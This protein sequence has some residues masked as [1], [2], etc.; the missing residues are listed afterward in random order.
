MTGF[1]ICEYDKKWW[2]VFVLHISESDIQVTAFH[3]S[4]ASKSFIYPSPPIILWIHIL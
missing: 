1:A 2:L 3:P 4:G